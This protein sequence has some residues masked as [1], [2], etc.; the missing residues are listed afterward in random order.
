MASDKIFNVK[1]LKK[2]DLFVV[3]EEIGVIVTPELKIKDL[4]EKIL[5]SDEFKNNPDF[6]ANFLVTTIEDRKSREDHERQLELMRAQNANLRPEPV[7]YSS[8]EKIGNLIKTIK[9]LSIQCQS[10]PE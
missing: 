7:Q 2:E 1:N 4:K 5:D 6:I 10:K 8:E 3:A 9:T